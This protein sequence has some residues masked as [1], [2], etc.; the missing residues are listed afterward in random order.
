MQSIGQDPMLCCFT[1]VRPPPSGTCPPGL[2]IFGNGCPGLRLEGL[3]S[4][5]ELPLHKVLASPELS[6]E[7]VRKLLVRS[8]LHSPRTGLFATLHNGCRSI[9]ISHAYTYSPGMA[10]TSLG[11]SGT[12]VTSR[13]SRHVDSIFF[14]PILH[15][16][17]T[18]SG[19]GTIVEPRAHAAEE[20]C[21][22]CSLSAAFLSLQQLRCGR[23]L[24]VLSLMVSSQPSPHDFATS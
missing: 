16:L 11:E 6:P 18:Q 4:T 1:E 19:N 22:C 9:C 5:Q 13:Q 7:Q 23:G 12:G 20:Q 24:E 3:S 10:S 8:Y 2:A 15:T 21:A 17:V 14:H